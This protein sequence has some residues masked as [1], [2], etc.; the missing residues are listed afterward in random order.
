MPIIQDYKKAI[1]KVQE[2]STRFDISKRKKQYKLVE[3]IVNDVYK[4]GDRALFYY[5]KKFDNVL[6]KSTRIPL[7]QIQNSTKYI[8]K[9]L[10]RSI[11]TAIKRVTLF[12]KSCVP[13]SWMKNFGADE[14]MGCRYVPLDSV[15][16]YIPSGKNPLIST[17]LMTVI[18]AKIAG[19]KRIAVFT[20][21]PVSKEILAACKLCGIKEIY[22]IGGAQA[23]AAA[24]YGT[25][26]MKSVDKIVG[27]GNIYVTLAK[28]IVFGRVGIEGLFGPSEIAVI[29]DKSANPAYIAADLLS[30]LEHGS[31]LESAFYVTNNKLLAQKVNS[32]LIKQAK[33]LPNKHVVLKSW[34]NNSAIV[35][36]KNLNKAVDLINML[37][38]EHLE[39][40]TKN[41]M[42][43]VSKIKHAGAIFAGT[44]SCES[45]GDYIAGPSHCLPTGSTAR[46][47]SGLTVMDFMK[48]VSII[49]F[50]KKSFIKVAKDVIELANAEGLPA[51]ADAVKTR[52]VHIHDY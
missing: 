16:V 45:I 20:P 52:L 36:V 35:V 32:L 40:I 34:K 15:G 27:P 9:D 12:Q 26:T 18:P 38:P 8:S 25:E 21:P 41:L 23:V 4:K 13:R 7:S 2:L 22:Q 29:A 28:K 51:H 11:K 30:Q 44:Y 1:K 49:S 19:V 43:L 14:K 47:S 10:L 48:K 46:F 37:A 42:K 5:T 33:K 39:I 3:K 50:G 17:V 24:A 31:G 6:L